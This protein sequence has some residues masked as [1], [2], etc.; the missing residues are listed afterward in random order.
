M[1][2]VI[3]EHRLIKEERRTGE[4]ERQREI[5]GNCVTRT[6][7]HTQKLVHM[8]TYI[9]YVHT[10]YIHMHTRTPNH[11]HTHTNTTSGIRD[12]LPLCVMASEADMAEWV[13]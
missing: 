7:A 10:Q 6:H 4:R 9:L 13:S 11:T 2:I 5:V 12:S 3:G 1:G 8:H